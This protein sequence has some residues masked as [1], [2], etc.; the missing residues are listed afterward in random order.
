[1]SNN[2]SATEEEQLCKSLGLSANP[3]TV[4]VVQGNK[5]VPKFVCQY[6]GKAIDS[7]VGIPIFKSKQTTEVKKL[8]GSFGTWDAVLAFLNYCVEAGLCDPLQAT[9]L[10]SNVHIVADQGVVPIVAVEKKSKTSNKTK[11]ANAA[12]TEGARPGKLVIGH[13]ENGPRY[14]DFEHLTKD[15]LVSSHG[16]RQYHLAVLPAPPGQAQPL[17]AIRQTKIL[18]ADLKELKG[19]WELEEAPVVASASSSDGALNDYLSVSLNS[20]LKKKQQKKR[21]AA[22][23]VA[24]AEEDTIDEV[25]V[26]AAPRAKKQRKASS[27]SES[28]QSSQKKPSPHP[29]ES[30]KHT[31]EIKTKPPKKGKKKDASSKSSN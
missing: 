6:H 7:R 2:T 9:R 30:R 27:V 1:M 10:S 28:K 5:R 12:T 23:P 4:L 20:P 31:L 18:N 3:E 26:A 16:L 29:Q 13:P 21:K 11:N 17:M 15:C 25:V 14:R 19:L 24:V 22:E 8:Y